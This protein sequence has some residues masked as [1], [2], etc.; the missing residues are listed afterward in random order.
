MFVIQTEGNSFIRNLSDNVL[1]SLQFVWNHCAELLFCSDHALWGSALRV[2]TNQVDSVEVALGGTYAAADALVRVNYVLTTLQAAVGFQLNF[3]F[4]EGELYFFEGMWIQVGVNTGVVSHTIVITFYKDIGL[5]EVDE[6]P[7]VTAGLHMNVAGLA[8]LN[9]TMDGFSNNIA[10]T[11]GINCEL[12]TGENVT[13]DE[14][15]RSAFYLMGEGVTLQ[16][17]ASLNRSFIGEQVTPYGS[18]TYCEDNSV[19]G[20]RYGI[21]LIILR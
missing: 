16:G 17:W 19:S 12:R 10:D 14:E 11:N 7:A 18:L 8:A 20:D 5:V 3:L 6:L 15:V 2:V 21:I 13:A 9:V 1:D 4:G